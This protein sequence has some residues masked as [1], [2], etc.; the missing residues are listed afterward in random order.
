MNVFEQHINAMDQCRRDA[1]GVESLALP[2]L[3]TDVLTSGFWKVHAVHRDVTTWEHFPH[4]WLLVRGVMR[5]PVNSPHE[6]PVMQSFEVY[7][8][9]VPNKLFNKQTELMIWDAM[10]LVW[11]QCNVWR[12]AVL[13]LLYFSLFLHLLTRENYSAAPTRSP[14]LMTLLLVR[15]KKV[16]LEGE[17]SKSN[18]K[19]MRAIYISVNHQ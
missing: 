9:L 11:R 17:Y 4:Y 13:L 2:L 16:E 14:Y 6:E 1:A 8:M 7:Q 15:R 18:E 12:K 3:C 5:S 10:P 19:A